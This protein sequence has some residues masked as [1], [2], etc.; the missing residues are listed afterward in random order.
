ME[1][2]SDEGQLWAAAYH[3][4][5]VVEWQIDKVPVFSEYT[6][7]RPIL[8]FCHESDFACAYAPHLC[9]MLPIAIVA[10]APW[11]RWRFS[12]RTLL[13]AMTLLALGL[14]IVAISN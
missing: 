13:I 1:G 4:G 7:G 5:Y 3:S 6:R 9:S 12:L 2:A 11:V 14:G 8:E 10:V